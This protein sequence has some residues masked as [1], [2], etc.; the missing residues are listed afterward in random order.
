MARASW[1]PLDSILALL[2]LQRTRECRA[3]SEAQGVS[4]A[5]RCQRVVPWTKDKVQGD[6]SLEGTLSLVVHDAHDQRA[7]ELVK[8]CGLLGI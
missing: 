1:R 4:R 8:L 3:L 6:S 5:V 2:L 7:R